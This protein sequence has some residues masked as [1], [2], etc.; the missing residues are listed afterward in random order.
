MDP[1]LRELQKEAILARMEMYDGRKSMVAAS[2]GIAVKTLYNKMSRYAKLDAEFAARLIRINE[3]FKACVTPNS[4]SEY[5][6][7]GQV[8]KLLG[9]NY[10]VVAKYFDR[11]SLAG[12]RVGQHAKRRID[13]ASVR[14]LAMRLGKDPQSLNLDVKFHEIPRTP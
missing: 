12:F 10:R 8:G 14:N 9:M 4:D 7:T 11:G 1:T 2:L 13:K 3:G 5:M 6:T